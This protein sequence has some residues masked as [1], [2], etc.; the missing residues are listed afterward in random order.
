[1]PK[2]LKLA[3]GSLA[4]GLLVLLIK[5]LA[6]WLTGSV[7]LLSDALE[8]LVNVATAVAALIALRIATAP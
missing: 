7:A 1:M 6:W 2:A 3:A 4:V 8:S 5:T